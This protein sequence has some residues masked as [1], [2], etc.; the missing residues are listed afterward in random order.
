MGCVGWLQAQR[1]EWG[2]CQSPPIYPLLARSFSVSQRTAGSLPLAAARVA[3]REHLDGEALAESCRAGSREQPGHSHPS[4]S[5]LW[6][7]WL[8]LHF[9]CLM[10]LA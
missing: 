9:C 7:L 3:G 8:Q 5:A 2:V 6:H 1:L 10:S 4:P